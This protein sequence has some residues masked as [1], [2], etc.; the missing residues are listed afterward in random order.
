LNSLPLEPVSQ[1][2]RLH[3]LGVFRKK[4]MKKIF[5]ALIEGKFQPKKLLPDVISRISSRL[6]TLAK[7]GPTEKE[8]SRKPRSLD[9]LH[10]FKATEYRQFLL[11]TGPTIMLDLFG[12]D[13]RMKH[14]LKL[15]YAVRILVS[16]NERSISEINMAKIYCENLYPKALIYTAEDFYRII[17]TVFCIWQTMLVILDL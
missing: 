8:F 16:L 1:T 10:R 6:I 2:S 17:R 3:A 5:E 11:Y 14:F 15:H 4:I 9:Y 7:Y 12:E 13:K